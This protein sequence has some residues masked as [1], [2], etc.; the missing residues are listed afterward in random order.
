M[1]VL[2]LIDTGS[3]VQCRAAVTN[4]FLPKTPINWNTFSEFVTV[5]ARLA[6][7]GYPRRKD[8]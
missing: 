5:I 1:E 2:R 8:C 6:F 3:T 4:S 7:E